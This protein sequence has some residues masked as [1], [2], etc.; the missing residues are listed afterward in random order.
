[1]NAFC[2][3]HGFLIVNAYIA[4]TCLAHILRRIIT[5]G[6]SVAQRSPIPPNPYNVAFCNWVP[7][8][9]LPISAVSLI[10]KR[11]RGKA[12]I[13]VLCSFLLGSSQR[14]SANILIDVSASLE[15][16]A[17]SL[18]LELS[19]IAGLYKPLMS[20]EILPRDHILQRRDA[21]LKAQRF[22]P[23]KTPISKANG[24]IKVSKY[25][26][27]NDGKING[28]IT[29]TAAVRG[30]WSGNGTDIISGTFRPSYSWFFYSP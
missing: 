3:I 11:R 20:R 26:V 28:C 24:E 13:P 4:N 10:E 7:R 5:L 29:K 1:M 25:N 23:R 30:S 14:Q 27:P 22:I 12:G 9:S 2:W 19:K 21:I 6:C 8:C 17:R 15:R 18:K 16:I